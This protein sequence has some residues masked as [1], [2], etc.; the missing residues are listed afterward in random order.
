MKGQLVNCIGPGCK[1]QVVDKHGSCLV[2]CSPECKH[3]WEEEWAEA[4]DAFHFP[5]AHG[6]LIKASPPS[7]VINQ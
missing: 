6:D 7:L 5:F 2:T 3:A 1:N 4:G